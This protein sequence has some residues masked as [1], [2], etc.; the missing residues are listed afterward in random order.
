MRHKFVIIQS[1]YISFDNI[2]I[3]E[4]VGRGEFSSGYK[5]YWIDG[6]RWVWNENEDFWRLSGPQNLKYIGFGI[7]RDETGRFMFVMRY[8]ENGNLY[9]YIDNNK[10]VIGWR[11]MTDLLWEIAGGLEKIHS[12]GFCHT[13]FTWRKSSD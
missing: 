2:E 9:E 10:G 8:Y 13:E 11:D 7:T 6:P 4:C 5:R 1:I 12:E 3:I